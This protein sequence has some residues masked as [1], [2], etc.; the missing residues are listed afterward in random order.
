MRPLQEIPRWHRQ[1]RPSEELQ[2]DYSEF[3]TGLNRCESNSVFFFLVLGTLAAEIRQTLAGFV[4][5]RRK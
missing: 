2:D 5:E 3:G 4:A 1:M